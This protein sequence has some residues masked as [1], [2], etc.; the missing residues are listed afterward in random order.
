MADYTD[1]DKQ[2]N[3]ELVDA[4]VEARKHGM[5]YGKYQAQKYA[6]TVKVEF[7]WK[8]TKKKASGRKK[9]NTKEKTK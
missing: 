3:Q 5:S 9:K 8:K 4:T 7:P 1:R 2:P 6:A